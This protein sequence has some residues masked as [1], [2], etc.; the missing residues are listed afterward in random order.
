[1]REGFIESVGKAT[2]SKARV[3]AVAVAV[4]V[5]IPSAVFAS[6]TFSDVPDSDWAHDDI[7]WLSDKGLTNG[8]GP[9][10]YCPD[11]NVTRREIAAFTHR[12]ELNLGT[13]HAAGYK[14]NVSLTNDNNTLLATTNLTVPTAGGVVTLRGFAGMD[15]A[16]LDQT[17]WLWIEVN[18][19]GLC[20]ETNIATSSAYFDT[21]ANGF[22]SPIT[23]GWF[24]GL[25]GAKRID[26]CV[27]GF[28][29]GSNVWHSEVEATWIAAGA[30]GGDFVLTSQSASGDDI[31]RKK[32]ATRQRVG[33]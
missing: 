7:S 21:Y 13:R 1:M 12:Q 8:C 19:G 30:T 5:L 2:R 23:T 22:A 16:A 28:G 14:D 9:G 10:I 29:E 24:G 32:E 18:N 11:G 17:G 15:D 3:V 27:W 26:L 25:V 6:H 4:L 33:G 31:G 20:N